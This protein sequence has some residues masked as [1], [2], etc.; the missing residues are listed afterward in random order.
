MWYHPPLVGSWEY[1]RRPALI[2]VLFSRIYAGETRSP[3]HP[4]EF[5]V[6][7]K[8]QYTFNDF[9]Q[10]RQLHARQGA[11]SYGT[12]IFLGLIA[13]LFY[14]YLIVL[15]LMGQGGR[16][17][18]LVP[19]ALLLVFLLF[20]YSYKPFLL[21]RTFNMQKDL[22]A[23]FEMELSEEGLSVSGPQAIALI[24]WNN[25]LKWAEGKEM[26]LLYSSYSAFQMLPKRLFASPSDLQFLHAQLAR[27]SVPQTGKAGK[28]K[29]IN[30]LLVYIFLF[31]ALLA[32]LFV[33]IRSIPR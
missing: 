27:N 6:Q 33:N 29:S 17:F 32:M 1:L 18:L 30:R 31:I 25:F 28:G 24:P 16:P 10:A 21:R 23:P 22:S 4:G 5:M 20:Q 13:M 7:I 9:K 14:I 8:G 15:E 3:Y 26:I 12:R 11:A 19:L 2:R